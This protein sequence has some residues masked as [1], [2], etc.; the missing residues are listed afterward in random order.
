[1]K[2]IVSFFLVIS[3]LLAF[4]AFL[5]IS[6]LNAK[7]N[8]TS[9]PSQV[10]ME[11][12]SSPDL[13]KLY[14]KIKKI[15]NALWGYKKAAK[16][17]E[18]LEKISS[19]KEISLYEKIKKVGNALWGIR[20]K[21]LYRT[22]TSETAP[23]VILAIET[24]D[25]AIIDNNTNTTNELNKAIVARTACQKTAL[26]TTDNQK[27]TLDECVRIFKEAHKLIKFNSSKTNITIAKTYGDSL[28]VCSKTATSVNATSSTAEK[29][30][31]QEIKIED[32]G[33][34]IT[35]TSENED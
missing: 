25:K 24:K 15:G 3:F 26:A 8:S 31:N 33:G 28:K 19:S 11:K 9:T 23:C 16:V 7:T 14:E 5:P 13:I 12:I 17:E 34:N 29:T 6:G 18:K 27:K 4:A 21:I 20:K 2:K 30:N 10:G 1:M 22:V 32:G 35:G